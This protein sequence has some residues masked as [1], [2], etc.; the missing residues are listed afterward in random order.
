LN[1]KPLTK[2][3][4]LLRK[5]L[6]IKRFKLKKYALKEPPVSCVASSVKFSILSFY[7][8]FNRQISF[9]SSK[10]LS[11]RQYIMIIKLI[12]TNPSNLYL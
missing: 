2:Y 6:N 11:A 7:V 12:K 5:L 10:I 8:K 1:P 9:D 3:N 4:S